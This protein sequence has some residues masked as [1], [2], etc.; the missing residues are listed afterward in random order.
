MRL[1]KEGREKPGDEKH[2]V[3]YSGILRPTLLTQE[4]GARF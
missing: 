2:C 3:P 4:R 1:G